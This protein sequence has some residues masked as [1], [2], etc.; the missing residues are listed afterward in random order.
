LLP[1]SRAA[2]AGSP[3][4]DVFFFYNQNIFPAPFGQL[5]SQGAAGYAAAYYHYVIG[6][7]LHSAP[8]FTKLP[9][10]IGFTRGRKV[11]IKTSSMGV[12]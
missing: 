12:P 3:G 10:L 7:F 8:P 2:A 11:G 6:F 4:G 5:K 9:S 1:D